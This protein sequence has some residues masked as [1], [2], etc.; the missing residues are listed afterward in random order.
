MNTAV[1]PSLLEP[2]DP[3][4][5]RK[6]IGVK[7]Q[8]SH[9][10]LFIAQFTGATDWA[11]EELSKWKASHKAETCWSWKTRQAQHNNPT[12]PWLPITKQERVWIFK[13]KSYLSSFVAQLLCFLLNKSQMFENG[14]HIG[15]IWR[16]S[17]QDLADTDLQ[18]SL[19]E[20]LRIL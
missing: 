13:K 14:K 12:W 20:F 1:F 5:S 6:A 17:S 9:G 7:A 18:F 16:C 8:L 19:R 4:P 2:S 11:A 15:I 10:W 3:P